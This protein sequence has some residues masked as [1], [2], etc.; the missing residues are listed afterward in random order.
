MELKYS[1]TSPYVR[2]VL[3]VAHEL[4]IMD[5]LQLTNTD[6]RAERA[7]LSQ[8]NPLSKIPTLI[9]DGGAVMF[10]SSVICEFLDAEF[11]DHRLLPSSG[12]RRWEILTRSVLAQGALDAAIFVRLEEMRLESERSAHWIATQLGRVQS[13]L[14]HFEATIAR[15]GAGLDL[16]QITLAC[17]LGWLQFRHS[18][19][20]WFD[21]REQLKRWFEEISQ[22]PS[23]RATAPNA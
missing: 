12:R 5:R 4:G 10:D 2:K 16:S 1:P 21:Q 8:L 19:R 6:P 11:G 13:V 18:A 9:T 20:P 22:R 14:D 3:V 17:T 15:S 23:L 7:S